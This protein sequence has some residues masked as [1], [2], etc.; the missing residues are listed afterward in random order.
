[1]KEIND[2]PSP[3]GDSRLE[4]ARRAGVPNNECNKKGALLGIVR[5]A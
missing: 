2:L 1:M 5:Q 4:M 3:E